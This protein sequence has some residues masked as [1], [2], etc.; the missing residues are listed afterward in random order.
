MTCNKAGLGIQFDGVHRIMARRHPENCITFDVGG[1]TI[2]AARFDPARRTVTHVLRESTPSHRELPDCSIDELRAELFSVT[3][4]LASSLLDG[5]SP[6]LVGFAFP[7]PIDPRGNVLSVP[8]VFGNRSR[9]PLPVGRELASQWPNADIVV[10]NDVTAA[11]YYY[12]RHPVESFCVTTVSSGIGNKVFIDGRPVVGPSGH[13]GEI[14]HI[15]VDPSPRAP[16]C[17]C[18]GRGHLGGIASG[19]GTL[20]AVLRAARADAEGF[21]QS[22]LHA[23]ADGNV[24]RITNEEVAA[25]FRSSDPWVTAR[26]T[27]VTTHLARVLAT[28]HNAIGIERFVMMGG[29]ALALGERYRRILADLCASSSWN[30]GQDWTTML[31]LG[32]SSDQ[33]GLI[34]AGRAAVAHWENR[35]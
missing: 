4:R 25:A 8:T 11:G 35:P 14:G 2:R 9:D 30:L 26:V 5:Q 7:G 13:G 21:R 6:Q 32:T 1:T 23:I 24:Q 29:F 10:M 16:V 12:R 3:S 27:E 33:A 19:R 34:G 22:S 28:I 18:G 15:V 20:A 31:E 17:D